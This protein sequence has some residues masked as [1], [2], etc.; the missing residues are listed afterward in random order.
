MRFHAGVA[1]EGRNV[2]ATVPQWGMQMHLSDVSPTVI[3]YVTTSITQTTLTLPFCTQ[4]LPSVDTHVTNHVIMTRLSLPGGAGT[5]TLT[6]PLVV[7]LHATGDPPHHLFYLKQH[8]IN[9]CNWQ[10]LIVR[11]FLVS[12]I[13]IQYVPPGNTGHFNCPS[14]IQDAVSLEGNPF[15]TRLF[16]RDALGHSPNAGQELMRR[17]MLAFADL[18]AEL[19]GTLDSKKKKLP[20]SIASQMHALPPEE[21]TPLIQAM[22]SRNLLNPSTFPPRSWTKLALLSATLSSNFQAKFGER[23][24]IYCPQDAQSC[25]DRIRSNCE[26][27]NPHEYAGVNVEVVECSP[28]A[29][30]IESNVNSRKVFLVT[31]TMLP[32]TT[33][34]LSNCFVGTYITYGC[35]AIDDTEA[36]LCTHGASRD[37]PYQ[38]LSLDRGQTQQPL[39]IRSTEVTSTKMKASFRAVPAVYN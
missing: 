32:E 35:F 8:V 37:M 16:G 9:T 18:H 1:Y 20:P 24:T 36:F 2:P 14:S 27:I 12:K 15:L 28:A 39:D 4:V 17:I 19:S 30:V 7:S 31:S 34:G 10:T 22:Q 13:L 11:A 5:V 6:A 21:E 25:K 38:G 26:G 3:Q 33:Y 23:Y 29:N